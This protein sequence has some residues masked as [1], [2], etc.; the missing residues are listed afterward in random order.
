MKFIFHLLFAICCCGTIFAQSYTPIEFG[1]TRWMYTKFQGTFMYSKSYC[2]F[3]K[4]TTGYYY[5]GNK[6]WR[7][8]RVEGPVYSP[9]SNGVYLFDDTAAR[10]VYTIDTVTSMTNVLNDFSLSIG[11]SVNGAMPNEKLYAD[12]IQFHTVNG[13]SRKHIYLHS[14]QIVL[15]DPV[16]WIEGIGSTF[17]LFELTMSQLIEEIHTLNCQEHNG[18]ANYGSPASCAAFMTAIQ[19]TKTASVILYPNPCIDV[20]SIRLDNNCEPLYAEIYSIDGRCVKKGKFRDKTQ[21]FFTGDLAK[22][23]YRILIRDKNQH[24]YHQLFYKE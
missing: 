18:F 19:D 16:V 24:Q 3:S 22:G 7:I 21:L 2:Y 11:D 5:G 4:D 23:C 13:I 15:P 12:S 14:N 9:T 10:K 8:E 17:N 20:L 1:N 6:Y